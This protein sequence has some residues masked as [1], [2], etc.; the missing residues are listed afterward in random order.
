MT[1]E[2]SGGSAGDKQATENT[3][4]DKDLPGLSRRD[5]LGVALEELKSKESKTEVKEEQP[6][7]Q[8]EEKPE[9]PKFEPPAEWTKE[10]KEDFLASS[11]R[12][13]EASLRLHKSRQGA[14]EQIRRE[15][16]DL[17][18]S[19]D[20]AKRVEG[21][22]KARGVKG[23]PVSAVID[24]L[25]TVNELN[26]K[27]IDGA[28]RVLKLKGYEPPP[29]LLELGKKPDSNPQIEALQNELNAVKSKLA[30]E[31]ATR[32]KNVLAESWQDFTSTK[33]AAGLAKFPDVLDGET[34]TALA[35]NIGSLVDGVTEFSKQF[36]EN[37]AKRIPGLTLPR[38]IEEAYRF[39]GGRVDDSPASRTQDTQKH[40]ARSSLA[41]TSVP[42]R[43]AVSS[44][45]PVKRFKTRREALQAAFEEVKA[46]EG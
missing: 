29:Q 22:L 35:R 18:W 37:T 19:R 46:R 24:A 40:I 6:A 36:I 44:V 25:D 17:E 42:G 4:G 20:L 43:S 32:F 16:A 14:L 23:D 13:Q 34:G 38:L 45:A 15:S 27:P 3:T 30:S 10:E 12:Q 28:A 26:E 39:Y 5:A 21:Y 7:P 1:N 9:A 41:A 31:E 8:K 2:V 11:P 33:N